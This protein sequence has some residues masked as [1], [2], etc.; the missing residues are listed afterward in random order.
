MTSQ[1]YPGIMPANMKAIITWGAYVIT[2]C[3]L[4]AMF[5][6]NFIFSS[7]F[8][9]LSFREIN[10]VAFHATLKNIHYNISHL[11]FNKLL[12]INDYGYGW[13]F[14]FPIGLITYPLY[15]LNE[16]FGVTWPLIIAPRE[17]S[18]IFGVLTIVVLRKIF[19]KLGQPE[20][21]IAIGILIFVLFP[22][23]GYASVH[24]GTTSEVLFFT[25]LST[26]FAII[27]SPSSVKGRL[28]VAAVLAVAGG[29]KLTGILI[30]PIVFV[31]IIFRYKYISFKTLIKDFIVATV[32]FSSLIIIF[33]NPGLLTY[34]FNKTVANNYLE[35]MSHFYEITKRGNISSENLLQRFYNIYFD[36]FP[37]LL[38]M[39]LLYFGLIKSYLIRKKIKC[40]IG[41][42]SF[43]L[44]FLM[45]YL[46]LTVNN[47]QSAALYFSAV[48]FI[49][50]YGVIWWGNQKHG[51]LVLTL[52]SF[53]LLGDIFSKALKQYKYDKYSFNHLIY[54]VVSKKS[55]AAVAI[56]ESIL[57]ILGINNSEWSGH[58]MID[59]NIK[60]HFNSLSLPN[61]FISVIFNNL[62]EKSKYF[63]RPVDYIILQKESI[64]FSDEDTFNRQIK[65]LDHKSAA[66]LINDRKYRK[67]I[68][69]G[70]IFDE[71][72]YKL[73]SDKDGVVIYSRK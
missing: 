27:D 49:S 32:V 43:L 24:F 44:F 21:I 14:W 29:V 38:A 16:H 10:D 59:W 4:G 5:L 53:L 35:T 67:I 56:S 42:I 50:L 26:Y 37:T 33:S 3:I 54:Y 40:E 62:S 9:V 6:E 7:G 64:G 47:G 2:T 18:L 66:E 45:G 30:S 13:I 58:I 31:L 70:G 72:K 39:V 61:A 1:K 46:F 71:K 60:T 19:I 69:D 57:N 52:V 12:E 22:T 65:S 73:V 55:C 11:N 25:V 17:L 48:S 20:W 63:N 28:K 68:S 15:L 36:G 41:V 34:P 23:F 51:V 8:D